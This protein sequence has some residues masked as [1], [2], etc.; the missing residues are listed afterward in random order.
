MKRHAALCALLALLYLLTGCRASLSGQVTGEAGQTLP[1]V[2]AGPMAPTGDS[3]SARERSVVLYLPDTAAAR[4]ATQVQQVVIDSGE[5][6]YEACVAALLAALNNTDFY[7]GPEPLALE[8]VS[9][10]VETCGNLATVYLGRSVRRLDSEAMAA[11]RLAIANTLTEFPEIL[12][13]NILVDGRDSGLDL[14]GRTLPTGVLTRYPSGDITTFWG[15][16]QAQRAAEDTELT[17]SAA[18]YFATDT[19]ALMLG[20]VRDITF[21]ARDEAV[22]ARALLDELAHGAASLTGARALVP[23]WDYFERD[24]ALYVPEGAS[25]RYIRLDLRREITD[26]L[27]LRGASLADMLGTVCYTLTGFIPSLDGITVYVGGELQTEM[28]LPDGSMW[29]DGEGLLTRDV[30]TAFAADTCTV[31]F[32]LADG[33]G[34]RAVERPIAQRFRTQPRTLL[35]EMMRAPGDAALM[36]V[37]PAAVGDADILGLQ[38]QGDLALVNLSAAFARAC[39]GF[40]AQQERNMIY[41]IVN[42]LTEADGVRRVR[43]YVEGQQVPIAGH[44]MIGGEY[45]R[46]AGLIH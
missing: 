45:M 26:Y 19:G 16:I 18:L 13:V 35:R 42:T 44:M 31:Y 43:F 41:A 12:Y 29:Y 9:N 33:S 30:F 27:R 4:L 40:T 46:H 10:P 32:A 7:T 39:A 21:A 11:L 20:E 8:R 38:V 28:V 34:L 3:Q 23:G 17:K 25:E 14:L 5:T 1:P 36:A 37:L 22:F 15:Q 24:P 6:V 2:A